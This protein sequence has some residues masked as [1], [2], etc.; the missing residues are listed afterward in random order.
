M[1]SGKLKSVLS[2]KDLK[3]INSKLFSMQNSV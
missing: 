1:P 2:A 3:P